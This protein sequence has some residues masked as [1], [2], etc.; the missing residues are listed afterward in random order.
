MK[1]LYCVFFYIFTEGLGGS[2][3]PLKEASTEL[4]PNFFSTSHNQY[5]VET[6]KCPKCKETKLLSE[7]NL[8]KSKQY[9]VSGRCRI[10][11]N[12]DGKNYLHSKDGLV[13]QIY[14]HQK[15]QSKRRGHGCPEYS[16]SELKLWL[17]SQEK[18]HELFEYWELG[19]FKRLDSPSVDRIDNNFGYRF[20]NIQL[21][22]WEENKNKSHEQRKL[23]LDGTGI[24]I[25]SIDKKTKEVSFYVSCHDA[26]RKT[27]IASTHIW[28]CCAKKK[29]CNSAG[30]KIW[31][32]ESEYR[33]NE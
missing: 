18:F 11:Q 15:E 20:D 6:K 9:G 25:V 33:I 32:K 13:T 16:K 3:Y 14:T 24:R 17:F 26:E 31:V 30:G 4:R 23:N 10:C 5:N 27:G 8:D 22:S 21:V 1:T 12:E 7:F 29:H 28:A 2:N 19:W